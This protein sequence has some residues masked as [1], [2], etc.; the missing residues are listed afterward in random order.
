[1]SLAVLAQL[2]CW[3]RLTEPQGSTGMPGP[4]KCVWVLRGPHSIHCQPLQGS[5]EAGT[6]LPGPRPG[7]KA[8]HIQVHR[9]MPLQPSLPHSWPCSQPRLVVVVVV[10]WLLLLWLLFSQGFVTYRRWTSN[11]VV[12]HLDS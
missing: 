6:T 8:R 10:L 2:D 9:G 1:M 12:P 4:V 11:A 7:A 5:T 3:K